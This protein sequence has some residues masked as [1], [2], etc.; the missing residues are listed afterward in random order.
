MLR[1]VHI[2]LQ[3][4]HVMHMSFS[5]NHI[6]A[7][8]FHVVVH[9]I[10]DIWPKNWPNSL[11][12]SP[13]QLPQKRQ[14]LNYMPLSHSPPFRS[15]PRPL[16][17]LLGFTTLICKLYQ[18]SD[19]SILVSSSIPKY[20]VFIKTWP[21]FLPN[22]ACK[23]KARLSKNI[24]KIKNYERSNNSTYPNIHSAPWDFCGALAHLQGTDDCF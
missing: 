15:N 19:T 21:L 6:R 24:K 18:P 4:P 22:V 9:Y 5:I 10:C 7:Q 16:I 3:L 11:E 14:Q 23:S 12:K 1:L 20:C 13:I 2:S 8:S 17:L